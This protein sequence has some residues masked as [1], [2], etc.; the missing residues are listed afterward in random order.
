M[1]V[2]FKILSAALNEA[3][4]D[5]AKEQLARHVVEREIKPARPKI[6]KPFKQTLALKRTR[7]LIAN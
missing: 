2:A 7:K 3:G 4:A 6:L 5:V 1:S